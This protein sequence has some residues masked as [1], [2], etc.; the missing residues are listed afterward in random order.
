MTGTLNNGRQFYLAG[1]QMALDG[2]ANGDA[3][4][5]WPGDDANVATNNLRNYLALLV[6]ND[7]LKPGD[8]TKLLSAPGSPCTV[9]SAVDATTGAV[10][11]TYDAGTPAL[12]VYKVKETDSSNTIF[13]AT[14]N[15]VYNTAP[16]GTAAPYGDKGFIV[17]RKGG[18][19]GVYQRNQA[20]TAGWN[21]DNNRFQSTIGRRPGDADGAVTAGDNSTSLP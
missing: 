10:T 7:Y 1:Q 17:I 12:K 14:A 19:A 2:A 6:K 8:L 13:A 5:V 15:Y 20:T 11:V 3:T 4:L 9:S 21:N 18:D 16:I